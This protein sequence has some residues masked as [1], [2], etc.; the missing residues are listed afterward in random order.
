MK[1]IDEIKGI[2]P[3]NVKLLNK[4]GIYNNQD[5]INY[6]LEKGIKKLPLKYNVLVQNRIFKPKNFRFMIE[7]DDDTYYSLA[8]MESAATNPYIIHFAGFS[9]ERPWFAN[10]IDPLCDLWDTYLKRTPWKDY[11]KGIISQTKWRKMCIL[12][13]KVL[14]ENVY[15]AIKRY[16]ERLKLFRRRRFG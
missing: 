11:K 4:L 10:S 12:A 7:K 9:L 8:E 5:L 1:N 15:A 3:K 13:L 14:P 6:S 2:G 16:E